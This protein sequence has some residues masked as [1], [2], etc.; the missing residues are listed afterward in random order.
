MKIM[1]IHNPY[2]EIPKHN[3]DPDPKVTI[4]IPSD[5]DPFDFVRLRSSDP[6]RGKTDPDPAPDPT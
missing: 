3:K 5:S 1:R 2:P 4:H 6:F